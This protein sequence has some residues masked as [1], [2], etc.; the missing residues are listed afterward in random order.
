MRR[1]SAFA[2]RVRRGLAVFPGFPVFPMLAALLLGLSLAPAAGLGQVQ[3]NF[4]PLERG[5]YTEDEERVLVIKG[6]EAHLDYAFRLSDVSA[7]DVGGDGEKSRLDQDLRLEL[8]TTYH[9]DIGVH[10]VLETLQQPLTDN[11]LR[12][13]PESDRSRID[14]GQ[15]LT[16]HAR[17]AFLEY[18]PNPNSSIRFGRQE[19]AIADRKG[20]V[21]QGIAPG[22]TFDCDVGTWCMPFGA[23]KIG[24]GTTDWIYHWGLDYTAWDNPAED[25]Q[26]HK[27]KVG[28]YRIYYSEWDVPLGRN[29]GPGFFDPANPT[30]PIEGQVTDD[31]G[32]AIYYDAHGHAVFGL[33][34]DWDLG[35]WFLKFNFANS[36][37]SRVYHR[38]REDGTGI[39]DMVFNSAD[40]NDKERRRVRGWAVHNELGRRWNLGEVG[41][42]WLYATGDPDRNNEDDGGNF[43]RGLSGYYELVPGA[44]NGTRYW[45]NGSD[46]R[47]DG[48]AGLG[49]SINNTRLLGFYLE[50]ADPE[51]SRVGY[52][53]GFYDLRRVYSVLDTSGKKQS[54]IGYEWDNML[55]WY[56]H[57]SARVQFE[58]NLFQQEEAFSYDDVTPPDRREDLI[59]QTIVR[60]VYG[61]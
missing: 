5:E 29:G 53:G 3:P 10:L 59:V 22:I 16:L 36:Q 49:H 35:A 19:V 26:P 2:R 32:N 6:I 34:V 11:N 9:R 30:A 27:L 4:A 48:G 61:F 37:G 44:Y 41:V 17:E 15:T 7:N 52:S 8:K 25:K 43:I 56:I 18:Y 28:I 47:V 24:D 40:P 21:F 31:G 42:R 20:M 57:K 12:E 39:P 38:F 14:D 51:G 60:I 55:T 58:A 13:Q 23:A 45:F 46:S 1:T 50:V 33:N 54:F